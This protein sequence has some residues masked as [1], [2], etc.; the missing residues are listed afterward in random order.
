MSM[1]GKVRLGS[2]CCT[3]VKLASNFGGEAAVFSI[4]CGSANTVL[5]RG[6]SQ[7]PAQG[8]DVVQRRVRKTA[9]AV[10]VTVA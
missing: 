9:G 1:D 6:Q 7:I 2:G 3:L 4:G 10:A 8:G 5:R